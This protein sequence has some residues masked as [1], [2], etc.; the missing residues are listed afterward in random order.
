VSPAPHDEQPSGP[1]FARPLDLADPNLKRLIVRLALPAMAGLSINA[2]H[3]V[4]NAGFVGTLGGE[5]L[6]AVSVAIPVFTLVAALGH[7]LGIGAAAAIGRLIGA[8][9]Q[10]RAGAT[11]TLALG[12]ALGFGLACSIILVVWLGPILALFGTTPA[13]QPLAEAYIGLLGLGCSLLLLQIVCD[14]I[15]IAEGNTRFSMWTL[16]GGFT[17]NIALDP[18]LIFGAGLGIGGAALATILSQIA[19]LA[20]YAIYFGKRWGIVRLRL[21][22]LAPRWSVLKPILAV[23]LPAA[24]SSALSAIAFALLYRAAGDQGGD[25]A[26][27]G[28]G[29]A[30]RI[31]T[32][33]ALPVLGFCL[34]AQAVLSH[35]WGAGDAARVLAA[36]RFM[37]AAALAFTLAYALV[38]AIFAGPIIG[39]FTEDAAMRAV[40]VRTLVALHLGFAAAGATYVL[41]VLLQSLGRARLAACVS[42]A[43]QGYLLLPLLI[44]LPPLWGLDGVIAAPALASGLTA[45]VSGALLVGEFTALRR[46]AGELP[47]ADTPSAVTLR[48]SA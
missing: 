31:M 27:A 22:D 42:L 6:A 37:L 17:L 29:I 18:L 5:A 13:M 33:G 8:G 28:I 34:G 20:A 45:L 3:H 4:A 47:G 30:L 11:A 25:M 1:G 32:L 41:T 10:G 16:L 9:D 12:L 26:V 7:G 24:A 23:G 46:R 15:A 21:T 48:G 43:P 19:A 39:L 36:T 38:M 35:G 2:L 44:I 40:G 14:F